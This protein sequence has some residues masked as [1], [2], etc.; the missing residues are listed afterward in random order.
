MRADDWAL[1]SRRV[2]GIVKYKTNR[3]EKM[4]DTPAK[5]SKEMGTGSIIVFLLLFLVP[6]SFTYL[7][8]FLFFGAVVD[9]SITEDAIHIRLTY[10]AI[11]YA[12]MTIGCYLRGRATDKTWLMVFPILG[13]FFDMF[14]GF[15]PFVPSVLNVVALVVGIQSQKG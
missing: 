3:M 9:E 10:L 13:G 6:A 7:S 12:I 2:A 4:N 5:R 1:Q 11:C 14:I 8:G 15:V